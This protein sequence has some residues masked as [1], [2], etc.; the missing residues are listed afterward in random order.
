[1]CGGWSESAD[2]EPLKVGQ[3]KISADTEAA[4]R[5]FNAEI[6]SGHLSCPS[7]ET[8]TKNVS[9]HCFPEGVFL[10]PIPPWR[11]PLST[12]EAFLLSLRLLSYG[13]NGIKTSQNLR[14]RLSFLCILWTHQ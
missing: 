7:H 11:V 12:P 13:A 3:A 9:R 5:L 4:R 6:K 2:R 10:N 1:M 8:N 14:T